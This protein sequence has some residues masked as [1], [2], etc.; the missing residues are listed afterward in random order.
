MP[1]RLTHLRRRHVAGVVVVGGDRPERF[2]VVRPRRLGH[3]LI[4]DADPHIGPDRAGPARERGSHPGQELIVR[5]RVSEPFRELGE[6]LVRCGT[7]AVDQPV[8]EP[9]RSDPQRLERDRDDRRRGGR[10]DRLTPAADERAD[11]R[12]RS[13]R[14]PR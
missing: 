11:R 9:L 1:D 2:G 4:P 6:H 5:V 14:T 7:F 8:G 10:Q 3:E 12:P 13:R